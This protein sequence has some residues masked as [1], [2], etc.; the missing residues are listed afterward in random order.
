MAITLL[1]IPQ[2]EDLDRLKV[3]HVAGTKGKGSTCALTESILRNCG[4]STGFNSSPHLMEVSFKNKSRFI[5]MFR[6][7]RIWRYEYYK[8]LIFLKVK[9]WE[10]DFFALLPNGQG[11][12]EVCKNNR[13]SFI[14]IKVYNVI[15]SS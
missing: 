2:T 15:H 4:Y 5:F 10:G 9:R 12:C 8:F 11:L 14:F 3:I 6:A 7:L 13:S 1:T